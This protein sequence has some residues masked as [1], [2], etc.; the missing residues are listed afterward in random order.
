[1]IFHVRM[2]VRPPTDLD[3]AAWADLAAR[4]KAYSQDLQRSG[5]WPHIWRIAGE[6]SNFSIFDVESND[7]LHHILSNLPLFAYMT[8]RVTPL[9]THPSDIKSP[10]R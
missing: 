5:Q 8:I 3:P 9:A 4:E 7:E 10:A 1:M 6:Y 2:D